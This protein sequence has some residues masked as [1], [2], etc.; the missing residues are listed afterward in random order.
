MK[1]F[2]SLHGTFLKKYKKDDISIML[3]INL[4]LGAI[5]KESPLEKKVYFTVGIL[6]NS[7]TV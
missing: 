7:L 4:L 2:I 3:F 1:L 5:T 6:V